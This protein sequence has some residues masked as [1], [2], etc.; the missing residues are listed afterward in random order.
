MHTTIK[1]AI[2]DMKK[3]QADER[4]REFEVESPST[5]S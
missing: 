1:A 2:D 3:N 4:E 5:T